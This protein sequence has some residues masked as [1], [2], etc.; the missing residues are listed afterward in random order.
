VTDEL[1][2]LDRRRF[3]RD[4]TVTNSMIHARVWSVA[5]TILV[6]LVTW[7]MTVAPFSGPDEPPHYLRA[8]SIAN[9]RLVGARVPTG[10]TAFN[11]R[12]LSPQQSAWVSR[13]MREVYVS[14]AMAPSL[15]TCIDGRADIRG[16]VETS[17]TGDYF[18]LPYLLPAAALAVSHSSASGL[19]LARLVSML[20]AWGLIA[21]TAALL[22]NGSITSLLGL[23]LAMSPMVYYVMSV[24]N[25]SA[26]EIAA[27]T[28]VTGSVLRISR[29]PADV[30]RYVWACLAGT[31]AVTVL[32]WQ[33]GPIYVVGDLVLLAALLGPA[34]LRTL[35][36]RGERAIAFV[37]LALGLA[38]VVWLA[39]GLAVGVMHSQLQV[40]L[41][42]LHYG[43]A[44]M[45]AVLHDAVYGPAQ[46]GLP[47]FVYWIWW[48]LIGVVCLWALSLARGRERTVLLLVAVSALA[49]PSVFFAWAYRFSGFPMAARYVLPTLMLIPMLA[50]EL[51]DRHARIS[52]PTTRIAVS[53][54]LAVVAVVEL[55]AWWENGEWSSGSLHR[56]RFFSF[57]VWSPPLGWW[58]WIV[59][60]LLGTAGLVA[61]AVQGMF[62]S[63][64]PAVPPG[65]VSQ[66]A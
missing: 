34:G 14:A 39:Y 53:A 50:G 1:V 17:G 46:Q 60:A 33:M 66:A 8:L 13:D 65:E 37:A 12:F 10:A 24:L 40:S 54:V 52:R 51:I 25:P 62:R 64:S 41:S 48:L 47:R 6:L 30:P 49:F 15:M 36:Q 42:S 4:A 31:A 2:L 63:V 27:A 58:P 29:D 28:A 11:L 56:F 32:S 43:F 61:T 19:R 38:G 57:A 22:W 26:M 9:G 20:S 45:S 18:P 21:L 5:L 35:W 44:Q 3:D 59:L 7:T 55:G 23:L 16:C